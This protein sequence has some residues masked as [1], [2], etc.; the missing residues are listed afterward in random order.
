VTP[1]SGRSHTS[2]RSATKMPGTSHALSPRVALGAGD[3]A[4]GACGRPFV[5]MPDPRSTGPPP[6]SPRS[7]FRPDTGPQVDRACVRG[8]RHGRKRGVPGISL[9]TSD[10]RHG[11]VPLPSD[12]RHAPVPVLPRLSYP[13]LSPRPQP[14][15]AVARGPRPFAGRQLAGPHPFRGASF[16]SPHPTRPDRGPLGAGIRGTRAKRHG[17]RA[18]S[19]WSEG[20]EATAPHPHA[21]RGDSF[22]AL[23]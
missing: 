13:A 3:E 14:A 5:R 1:V 7:T 20:S 2:A 17:F 4:P 9:T 21:P 18:P 22:G 12:P 16:T 19:A 15:R 10:L 6:E 11:S 23:P 8:G